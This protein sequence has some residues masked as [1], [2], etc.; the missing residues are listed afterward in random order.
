MV[1]PTPVPLGYDPVPL[2]TAKMSDT[3]LITKADLEDLL[4]PKFG[5]VTVETLSIRQLTQPGENYGA[6][7]LSVE[8]TLAPDHR[9]MSI[10]AK[11]APLLLDRFHFITVRKEM[12]FYMLVSPAYR[13][14]QEECHVPENEIVDLFP[15]CYGVRA[16]R[17][18]DVG[19][20]ADDGA[21]LLME[22]LKNRGYI[23]GNR[24]TGVDLAHTRLVMVQ[25]ARFHATAVA[26]KVNKPQ[27]FQDTV[28]K[29]CV[30][31][32]HEPPRKKEDGKEVEDKS[33]EFEK[34]FAMISKQ[35]EMLPE[36]ADKLDRMKA[37]VKRTMEQNMGGEPEE[38]S[39]P[40]ASIFHDD[41]CV[42]NV[43]D[44]PAKD[45]LFFL[46]TSTEVGLVVDHFDDMVRLYHQT[47]TDWLT[48]L[49]CDT[50]PFSYKTF[51]TEINKVAPGEFSRVCGMLTPIHMLPNRGQDQANF[52][53]RKMVEDK[54]NFSEAYH[55]KIIQTEKPPPVHPTEI[56]TSISAS[57]AAELNTT[58]AL[59]NYATEAVKMSDTELLTKTDLEELLGQKFGQVTVE[60]ISVSQ[61]TQPGENYGANL[62]SIEV[63]LAPDHKKLSV[64]A[65]LVPAIPKLREM[66]NHITV[67][68]EIDF[69]LLVSPAYRQIQEECHI[70][71]NEIVDLF[72]E[73]YGA[74]ATRGPDVGQLPDDGAALLLENLKTRGYSIG[75]RLTGVDLAHTRL[76]MDTVMKSCVFLKKGPPPKKGDQKEGKGDGLIKGPFKML[77]RMAQLPELADKLDIMKASM[78]R[79]MDEMRSGKRQQPSE[80]FASILHDDLC[81]YDS[82]AK[83]LLFFLF[84]STEVGIVVDH[85][86]D[87]VRLY[88]QT[89]TDWLVTLRC[90]TGPFSYQAFLTEINKVAPGEFFR[91][92]TMLT[93]IH[94]LPN[95]GQGQANF[96]MNKMFEDKS[97]FSEAYYKKILQ[98][99]RD[100]Q[101][102]RRDKVSHTPLDEDTRAIAQGPPF[103]RSEDLCT[104]RGSSKDP[105]RC[106]P[107]PYF[108]QER[109][110]DSGQFGTS[111]R[112]RENAILRLYLRAVST[113]YLV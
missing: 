82:P 86:D 106:A 54:S 18:P 33:D 4:K 95:R 35:V 55:K 7:V 103:P 73:C 42:N 98:T 108:N 96:D 62:L 63:T 80:P 8:I 104:K 30:F 24:L 107:Q 34:R 99:L 22:N 3:E 41:L 16:T 14:I 57:S 40:F 85:F 6:N 113:V 44:S 81:F 65:K 71:E 70:P 26:L 23:I 1:T 74:R 15:E 101:L 94:M 53:M 45:L 49:R 78:K 36:L 21:V 28:M 17:G 91:I 51:L 109:A 64:V 100:Q 13:Q 110:H 88:H 97:N 59:A 60:S 83:D 50:G 39:E 58:S 67:R 25:M 10:V 79:N 48:T 52:N 92:M 5:Q 43:Y 20:S 69:Y 72:P 32:K 102:G 27:V 89:F 2:G 31:F 84:T 9:R 29:S 56:R 112:A 111:T 12:D 68:K 90:D 75:D 66:F 47:F 87:M 93:P 11:L 46:F 19:Q 105:P 61:L 76:V 77:D 37:N 38:P